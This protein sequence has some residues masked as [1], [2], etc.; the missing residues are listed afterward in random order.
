MLNICFFAKSQYTIDNMI[1]S[2]K[3][4]FCLDDEGDVNT[5]L[6]V[7]FD[8]LEDGKI[9]M[10]HSDL[11][12]KTLKDVGIENDSK[13]HDTAAVMEPLKRH[14]DAQPFNPY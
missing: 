4:D 14:T 1:T 12:D 11:I 10:S 3:K 5:F 13:Y 9:K 6:G 7:Q 2:L 8:Y